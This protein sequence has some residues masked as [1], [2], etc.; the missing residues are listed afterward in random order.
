LIALRYQGG[1]DE[2]VMRIFDSLLALLALRWRYC[3]WNG[4]L[5]KPVCC[6]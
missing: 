6:W 3:C 1:L 4:S 2:G 5:P